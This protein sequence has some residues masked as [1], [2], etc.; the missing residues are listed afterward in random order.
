VK[1]SS[2]TRL[3]RL[4]ALASLLRSTTV[5]SY[6]FYLLISISPVITTYES[7]LIHSQEILKYTF[8]LFITHWFTTYARTNSYVALIVPPV[9]VYYTISSM[10]TIIRAS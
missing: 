4:Q 10:I 2:N 5:E 6:S 9:G 8:Y 1:Y 7:L 3:G